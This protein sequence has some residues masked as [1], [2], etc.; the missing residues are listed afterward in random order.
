MV[1]S[2]HR[3][4]LEKYHDKYFNIYRDGLNLLNPQNAMAPCKPVELFTILSGGMVSVEQK[5]TNIRFSLLLIL[6]IIW[7]CAK[8]TLIVRKMQHSE[9]GAFW[10]HNIINTT[11]PN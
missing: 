2:F 8:F 10:D 4:Q 11:A 5:S 6:R 9:Y 3:F 7:K 1:I